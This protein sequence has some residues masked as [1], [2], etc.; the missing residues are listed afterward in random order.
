MGNSQ[1]TNTRHHHTIQPTDTTT[2]T[3]KHQTLPHHS[4]NRHHHHSTTDTTTTVPPDTITYHSTPTP[5]IILYHTKPEHTSLRHLFRPNLPSPGEH[6]PSPQLA[7]PPSFRNKIGIFSTI[8]DKF[9]CF[10]GAGGRH[11][12]L[13]HNEYLALLVTVQMDEDSNL[14]VTGDPCLSL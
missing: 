13:I 12:G 8:S 14:Q 10:A 3:Y 11:Y 1:L 2:I 7:H 9:E 4:I 5:H 6:L